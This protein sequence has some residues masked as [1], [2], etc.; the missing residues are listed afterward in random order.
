MQFERKYPADS[1]RLLCCGGH[2]L[3]ELIKSVYNS[4]RFKNKFLE[5]LHKVISSIQKSIMILFLQANSEFY[6]TD[7]STYCK[8][9]TDSISKIYQ[10]TQH[11]LATLC[12]KSKENIE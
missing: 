3:F 1:I 10:K 11:H 12:A 6:G 4:K 5:Q 7:K 2:F 9:L 8:L